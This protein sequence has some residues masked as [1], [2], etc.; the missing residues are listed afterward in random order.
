MKIEESDIAILSPT[1][2]RMRGYGKSHGLCFISNVLYSAG[3]KFK[4]FYEEST[5][6]ISGQVKYKPRKGYINLL[7]YMGSK[8]LE[9]KYVILID[10]NNLLLNI[11]TFIE[12]IVF[13][14]SLIYYNIFIYFYI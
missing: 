14:V 1:R 6:E 5:D 8:G 4:Q 7:T 13:I 12:F 9:W 10:A 3:F 2:G 11:Y